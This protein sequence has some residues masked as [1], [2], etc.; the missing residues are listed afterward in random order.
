MPLFVH[1]LN[2]LTTL[3][4]PPPSLPPSSWV[5]FL[6]KPKSDADCEKVESFFVEGGAAEEAIGEVVAAKGKGG[7]GKGKGAKGAS[8]EGEGEGSKRKPGLNT[9]QWRA[10]LVVMNFVKGLKG[11]VARVA[12]SK[13]DTKEQLKRLKNSLGYPA[14][15]PVDAPAGQE[16]EEKERRLNFEVAVFDAMD[17]GRANMAGYGEHAL[18]HAWEF[19]PPELRE[20]PLF[21]DDRGDPLAT[22]PLQA[23]MTETLG[24]LYK[25]YANAK[26]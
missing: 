19:A 22:K 3:R 14:G 6:A 20:A 10:F 1:P 13:K 23:K 11:D 17:F 16:E 15:A 21:C 4:T 5:S 26:G 2:A 25:K 24:N 18:A 9:P 8:P 7:K 12:M